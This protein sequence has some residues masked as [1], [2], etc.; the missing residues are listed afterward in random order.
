MSQL[1][2]SPLATYKLC[3][4]YG[5][6]DLCS[7]SKNELLLNLTP[8]CAFATLLAT[9][10][11]ADLQVEVEKY[12]LENAQGVLGSKEFERCCDEVSAGEVSIGSETW[13]FDEGEEREH[14]QELTMTSTPF[15]SLPTVGH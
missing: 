3:H 7:L 5:Q 13:R 1:S 10:Y 2:S 15:S 9:Y 4:R 14:A 11:Y 12:V 8:E 6:L